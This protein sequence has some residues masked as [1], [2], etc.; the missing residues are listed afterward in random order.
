[1]VTAKVSTDMYVDNTTVYAQAHGTD[2]VVMTSAN[3]S[4]NI[5]QIMMY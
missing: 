2:S 3:F 4:A 5:P 1:M